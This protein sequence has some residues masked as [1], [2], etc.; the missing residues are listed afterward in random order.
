MSIQLEFQFM[1][2]LLTPSELALI[3]MAYEDTKDL[4]KYLIGLLTK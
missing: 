4:D 3:L 1:N 2:D